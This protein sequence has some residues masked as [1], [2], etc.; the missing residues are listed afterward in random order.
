YAIDVAGLLLSTALF[1]ALR[2]YP[3]LTDSGQAG[4]GSAI[5]EIAEGMRYAVR[6]KDLLGTY[7]VDMTAMVLAM[8]VVLFPALASDVF[9]QPAA[10][11]LLYSASTVGSLVATATSG[12]T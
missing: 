2:P 5:R 12:W 3:P 4:L 9:H 7:V 10:L 6:R 11:G 1:A 8:P